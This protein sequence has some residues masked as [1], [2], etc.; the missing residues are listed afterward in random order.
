MR[1][2]GIVLAAALLAGCDTHVEGDAHAAG[3]AAQ[4]QVR[5]AAVEATSWRP[6]VEVTGSAEPVAAVQLGFDVPGR[7]K[8][9][10]VVRGQVVR[11]GDAIAKLDASMAQSQLAQA[12]AGE[13]AATAQATAAT[14]S[15]ARIEKLGDAVSPQQRSEAQAGLEGARAQLAQAEAAVRLARTN[16]AWH[17]LKAPIGGVVTNGPDNAG[18]LVG[19]GTPLFVIEDLSALRLKG[20][21]AE[22][23]AWVAEGLPVSVISGVGGDSVPGV[24]ER[25]IPALDPATR[26]IPVE[27][28]IDAPP[29]S[30][31]SHAFVR[32]TVEGPEQST[33]AIPRAALVARPE[34]A[35]WR[36]PA[37]GA[38]PERVRVAVL[39][40]QGDRVLVSGALSVG[41]TVVL[42]PPHGYGD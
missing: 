32:A 25:V 9:L 4:P 14:S 10:V 38:A 30:L 11:A 13:A 21:V 7:L 31:R 23:H 2:L 6:S 34:F 41:D 17:T 19:A 35:V 5:T 29:P 12:Q 15:F 36:L 24:V 18:I 3:A 39:A 8:E 22:E 20:T 40:E 33:L 27:I 1:L 26:R 16:L 42:D 28:R 37:P